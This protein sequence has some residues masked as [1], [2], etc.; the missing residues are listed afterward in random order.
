M[1]FKAIK[2]QFLSIF[3]Q[4]F[5]YHHRSLEFRCKL[6]AAMIVANAEAQACEYEVLK[7]IAKE[8]YGEDEYRI[9]VMIRI[10]KEYVSKVI[11]YNSLNLDELLLEIDNEMKL[12]KRFVNKINLDH[13]QRFMCE[14]DENSNLTQK[15]ILEF[16]ESR[17]KERT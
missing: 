3:R 13:L 6:F 15:R 16:F 14:S 12:H 11:I 1:I 2:S 17:I 5:V 4:I 10:T 9:E 7:E 8:I